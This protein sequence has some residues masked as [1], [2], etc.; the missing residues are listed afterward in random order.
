MIAFSGV[1][2]MAD[3]DFEPDLIL[4]VEMVAAELCAGDQHLER[5]AE[6][7]IIVANGPA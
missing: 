7:V 5:I 6:G 2:R 4:E 3:V 1:G